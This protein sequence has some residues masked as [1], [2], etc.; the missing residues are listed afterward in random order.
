MNG[1]RKRINNPAFVVLLAALIL[2]VT[3]IYLEYQTRPFSSDDV[4]WQNS[5]A[6]WTPFNGHIVDMGVK[7]NFI[8]NMLLLAVF[9]LFFQPSRTLLFVEA[10]CFAILNF[11]L[12]YYAALY[13]LGKCK[14]QITFMTLM[15]TLWLASFGYNFALLYM[16]MN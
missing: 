13:F 3:N 5:L 2:I 11:L 8:V 6:T 7:D 10:S 9:G 1:L 15:P 4:S 12:F 14:I 16:N